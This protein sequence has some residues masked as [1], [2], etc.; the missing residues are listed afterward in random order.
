[1]YN[2]CALFII[3]FQNKLH[4]TGCE[5]CLP[6]NSEDQFRL[7]VCEFKHAI[8]FYVFFYEFSTRRLYNHR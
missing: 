2:L 8:V 4:F 5:I 6:S 3:I 7:D 1:M